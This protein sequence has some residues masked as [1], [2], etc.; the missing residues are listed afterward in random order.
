MT[1]RTPVRGLSSIAPDSARPRQ[2]ALGLT[3]N[4]GAGKSAA[5]SIFESMGAIVVNADKLGHELLRPGSDAFDDLVAEFGRDIIGED[6]GINRKKLGAVVFSSPEKLDALNRISHPRIQAEIER[7]IREFRESGQDG[8]LIID[9][10]LIFEWGQPEALD[11]IMVIA[12]PE[13][14][15][16]RRFADSRGDTSRF[17]ARE[18]AQLPQEEKIN[19]ADVT[20][21]NASSLDILEQAIQAFMNT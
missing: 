11:G 7:R 18:A 21:W 16:R 8:P 9:A 20:L 13:A 1:A 2:C 12:A 10:A 4:P 19:R 17:D 5:A 15:R 14:L 6:G 3:G